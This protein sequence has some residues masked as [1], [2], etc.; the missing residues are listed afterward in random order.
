MLER[1]RMENFRA[2]EQVEIEFAPITLLIGANSTGKSSILQALLLL[3]QSLRGGDY[4]VPLSFNG[5][6]VNM[7]SLRETAWRGRKSLYFQLEWDDYRGI[8]FRVAYRKQTGLSVSEFRFLSGREWYQLPKEATGVEPW[9]FSFEPSKSGQ[10]LDEDKQRSLSIL[11]STLAYFFQRLRYIGPLRMPAR[12]TYLSGER[13]ESVGPDARN[14][15]PFLFYRPEVV[16]SIAHW[17]REQGLADGLEVRETARGSGRWAVYIAERR[18]RW[19]NLVNTGFGYSQLIPVL[20]EI[21]GAPEG[22]LILVEQP[23]LHLNPRLAIWMGDVLITAIRQGKSLLVETHS[24]H[25]V[26]RLRRRIAEGALKSEELALYFTMRSLEEGKSSLQRI[27]LDESGQLIEKW[28]EDFWGEDY[29]ETYRILK[30][31]I[32]RKRGEV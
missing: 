24:E 12:E 20:A 27:P 28:P 13:P 4:R 5:P 15:I 31:I 23:E 17:L 11:N 1:M 3:K 18:G 26:L 22:S 21:Y 9:Y 29:A 25:I 32:S 6:L 2:F 10:G 16:W 8:G 14:L 30:A 7:G 19:V